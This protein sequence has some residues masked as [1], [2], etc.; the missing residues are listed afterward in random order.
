MRKALFI[1]LLLFSVAICSQ[2]DSSDQVKVGDVLVIGKPEGNSY[3][4]I[5][6]PK[7]NFIIKRGGIANL[8]SLRHTKV[9]V[10][11]LQ[12]KNNKLYITFKRKDGARFFGSHKNLKAFVVEGIKNGELILPS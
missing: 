10:T 1:T 5:A 12:K 9:V 7:K 6:I 2:N 8:K 11:N 3:R 4:S